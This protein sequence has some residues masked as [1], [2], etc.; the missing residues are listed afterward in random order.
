MVEKKHKYDISPLNDLWTYDYCEIIL[1]ID[2]WEIEL[3]QENNCV[4]D[5]FILTNMFMKE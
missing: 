1:K 2:N 4:E 3:S 5:I